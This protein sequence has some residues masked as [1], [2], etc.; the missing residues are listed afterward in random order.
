VRSWRS[1]RRIYKSVSQRPPAWQALRFQAQ[2]RA[3][4]QLD[5]R[6]VFRTA[7]IFFLNDPAQ[8]WHGACFIFPLSNGDPRGP[9]PEIVSL[10]PVSRSQKRPGHPSLVAGGP[11]ACHRPA[12]VS[13]PAE[14]VHRRRNASP[15]SAPHPHLGPSRRND[16]PRFLPLFLPG[17]SPSS[18]RPSSPGGPLFLFPLGNQGVEREPAMIGRQSRVPCH[19]ESDDPDL[20]LRPKMLCIGLVDGFL[21]FSDYLG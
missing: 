4:S 15:G 10:P 12:L 9:R 13:S 16:P 18:R 21:E 19:R 2:P 6:R 7:D 8:G 20:F 1:C 5:G 11:E 3:F 17:R 14:R